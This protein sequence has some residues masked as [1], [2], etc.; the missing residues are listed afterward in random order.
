MPAN[1]PSARRY[2]AMVYD[3]A[4][5]KVL[6][7]GGATGPTNLNDTWEW[8]G[9]NWSLLSPI[10]APPVRHMH[11]MAY[12]VA[13]QRAVMFGGW[14]DIAF[15]GDT[16]EWDG[17]NWL[18]AFSVSYPSARRLHV[19]A[20]DVE[21]QRT[22]LFAGMNPGF[23]G[24]AWEW[25]GLNWQ[26]RTASGSDPSAREQHAMVYDTTR[27]QVVLFGGWGGGYL[28]DTWLSASA[29][30][31]EYG[32]GCGMP[33]LGLLRNPGVRPVLGQVCTS[34]IINCPTA[35]VGVAMGWSDQHYGPFALPVPLDSIGMAGCTLWQSTD[36]L[37]L[38][39]TPMSSP[40]PDTIPVVCPKCG[41]VQQEPRTAYST[42]CKRCR[43]HVRIEEALRPAAPK[44]K[45]AFDR[46]TIRC[47]QCG[48]DLEVPV[49]AESTMCKRCSSHV[50]LRDYHVAQTLSKNFRTH[51]KLVVEE[52]GYVLNTDSF[53]GDAVIKGRVI[54][55]IT[56]A[57]ATAITAA[58]ADGDQV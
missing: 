27:Q 25:D 1:Q 41:H 35:V 16:W 23:Q 15:L 54:G 14:N 9:I 53:V 7:F 58:S 48:T 19:M 31:T 52:K 3:H 55:K 44:P 20:F 10:N 40:K 30:A 26:Q 47:F 49:A 42:V 57:A 33:P 28:N 8:D 43:N 5:Q 22:V 2:S 45:P 24:D 36:V 51:G 12:D 50:D 29:S 6:L 11:A 17:S 38:G 32:S 39:V 37:A 34:T 46:K 18:A 56:A 4:R 21:R 13:R